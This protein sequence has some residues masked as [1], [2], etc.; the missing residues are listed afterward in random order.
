[1]ENEM[2]ICLSRSGRAPIGWC[3]AVCFSFLSWLNAT[4]T[5]QIFNDVLQAKESYK[6]FAY[7]NEVQNLCFCEVRN[8]KCWC[9]FLIQSVPFWVEKVLVAENPMS[10]CNFAP[11]GTPDV[12]HWHLW[13]RHFFWQKQHNCKERHFSLIFCSRTECAIADS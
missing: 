8:C 12:R 13:C 4:D 2:R 7:V 10:P 6:V 1:M 11:L 9:C 5:R 3:F